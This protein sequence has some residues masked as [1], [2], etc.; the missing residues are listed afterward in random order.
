MKSHQSNSGEVSDATIVI[1]LEE[2]GHRQRPL[3]LPHISP[4]ERSGTRFL[5][6]YHSA[7]VAAPARNHQTRPQNHSLRIQVGQFQLRVKFVL[8]PW[9]GRREC[10]IG[11]LGGWRDA[12]KASSLARVSLVRQFG[13][14]TTE[15]VKLV[16]RIRGVISFIM[17][18]CGCVCLE[19]KSQGEIKET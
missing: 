9:A 11:G 4:T 6:P 7:A 1:R 19:K 14:A 8:S 13:S 2:Q 16:N 10:G 5:P 12:S 17:G 3:S 15:V 18:S